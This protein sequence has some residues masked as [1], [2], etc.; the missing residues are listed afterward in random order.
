[1]VS[2][3]ISKGGAFKYVPAFAFLTLFYIGVGLIDGPEW[4]VDSP[5]YTSM[6]FSREPVYPLFLLGLRKIF[7]IFKVNV[8][9][10]GQPAYLT[11]AI[12]L[13]SM[14]WVISGVMLGRYVYEIS[15]RALSESRAYI[16]SCAA[17]GLQVAVACLNRFVAIRGS[18][19]SETIMT[20]S[21]AMPL[22]VIF[23]VVLLE[24]LENYNRNSCLKLFFLAVLMG[25]IRKQMLIV[26]IMWGFVSFVLHLFVKRYRSLNQFSY[27]VIAV[28]VAFFMINLLD[29]TYNL[30]VRGVFAGHTGNSKGGLCTLLYTA[31]YGD[32]VIFEDSDSEK[33]PEIT[34]LYSEI[35]N[36][37]VAQKLTIDYAPGYELKEKSTVLNSDW[38][39]MASH[40]AESYDVIGFEIVLPMCDEYVA[41]H[42]PGLE[43][44]Y[45]KIKE[46]EVE[47]ELF[48]RLMS[49]GITKIRNGEDRGIVYV[50]T[51]NVLKAM[52]ISVANI[53][54]RILVK[55]SF[56]IYIIFFV[57][58]F[59][60]A[61]RT[62]TLQRTDERGK[63]KALTL[64]RRRFLVMS[65]VVM[66]GLIINCVV[67][68]SMI[69]PQPRYMCYSMGLFYLCL[70]CDILCQ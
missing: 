3:N 7:E 30:A 68:G 67:T 60:L 59:S 18:M 57:G 48:K 14:L 40:Y 33:F 65:F 55:V 38:V 64:L 22:F 58:F 41:K 50:F 27:T 19:Y 63:D 1:M 32:A 49:N 52:V 34:L 24:S 44:P 11:A 37:C 20:E 25:S 28:V 70:C 17:M 31:D 13:Q 8:E 9:A 46:N 35:Y 39:S 26:L 61:V 21:L 62:A 36:E 56:I 15:S 51:A 54:P 10:Y 43:G 29:C 2:K 5:S 4:C 16:L 53:S 45:A 66:S 23:T 69:F 6:D 12:I 42:F 47:G